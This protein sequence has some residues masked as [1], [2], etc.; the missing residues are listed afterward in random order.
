MRFVWNV[1][2][3]AHCL[4]Q[5]L[6]I[7]KVEYLVEMVIALAN[8]ANKKFNQRAQELSRSHLPR[9]FNQRKLS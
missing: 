1:N 4:L 8:M 9:T 3:V 6:Q 2:T 5:R 7:V